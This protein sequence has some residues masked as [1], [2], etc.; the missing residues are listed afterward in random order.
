MES[1]GAIATL[2]ER[3]LIAHNAHHLFMTTQACLDFIAFRDLADLPPL[4]DPV[5]N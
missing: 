4:G 5:P 2:L 1:T 3:G